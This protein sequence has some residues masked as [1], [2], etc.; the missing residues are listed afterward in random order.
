VPVSAPLK[1]HGG[2]AQETRQK[3]TKA[4]GQAPTAGFADSTREL[5]LSPQKR[6]AAKKDKTKKM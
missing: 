6:K 5:E 1:K 4:Q 3:T 2:A